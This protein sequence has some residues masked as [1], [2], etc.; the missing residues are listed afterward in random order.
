MATTPPA[1]PEPTVMALRSYHRQVAAMMA[2]PDLTG[3]LLL[4]G[5]YMAWY[6]SHRGGALAISDVAAALFPEH[7]QR[8]RPVMAG[9]PEP[10]PERPDWERLER[11]MRADIRRYDWT[12]GTNRCRTLERCMA[13]LPRAGR[14]CGGTNHHGALLTDVLTGE[15][16]G[17]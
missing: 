4:V 2:D 14:P 9:E 13:P 1:Q 3:D 11:V 16:R 15:R 7:T 12:V 17:L 8:M 6:Y 10:Q 5:L